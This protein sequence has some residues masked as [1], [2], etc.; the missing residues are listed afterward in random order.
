METALP[1]HGPA[2]RASGPDA[3][4]PGRPWSGRPWSVRPWSVRLAGA[5]SERPAVEL[6]E[7]GS[8]IDVVSATPL[9][10]QSLRGGRVTA[11][12]EGW[13]SI[14]WGRLP[15]PADD[16]EVQF[17]RGRFRRDMRPAAVIKVSGWCWLAVADG[18]FDAVT[19]RLTDRSLRL[20]LARGR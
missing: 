3:G 4:P 18:R 1:D 2:R 7:A 11:A 9:A 5:Q 13:R 16:L 20:R 15:V 6:Y 14:A 12:A 17:S 10:P 19:V 8:L